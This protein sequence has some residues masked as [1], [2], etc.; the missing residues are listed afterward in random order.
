MPTYEVPIVY[1]GQQTLFVVADNEE[2]AV[3]RARDYWAN[4]KVAPV[5]GNEGEEIERIGEVKEVPE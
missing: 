1:R 5:L 3:A 4:G 2:A